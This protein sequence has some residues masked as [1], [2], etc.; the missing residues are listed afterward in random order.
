MG[1]SAFA[2]LKGLTAVM[3][4]NYLD[5]VALDIPNGSHVGSML[6]SFME[7]MHSN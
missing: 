2:T 5:V 3:R 4:A 7:A 6:S 1:I